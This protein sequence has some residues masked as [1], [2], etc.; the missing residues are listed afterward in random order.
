MQGYYLSSF[1]IENT[2][3]LTSKGLAFGNKSLFTCE[4]RKSKMRV[5]NSVNSI[6][7]ELRCSCFTKAGGI[8]IGPIF[9]RG[10]CKVK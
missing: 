1:S 9:K 4:N 8:E 5:L 6:S 7:L 3:C 2:V 10:P